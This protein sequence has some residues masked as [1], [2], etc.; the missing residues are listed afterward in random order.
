MRKTE[1]NLI[2]LYSFMFLHKNSTSTSF[3]RLT[4]F[5]LFLHGITLHK[6]K[7]EDE[8][9]EEDEDEDKD[10]NEDEEMDGDEDN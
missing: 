2:I 6:D 7:D 4:F 8:E 1:T 10:E 5:S 3:F 9:E